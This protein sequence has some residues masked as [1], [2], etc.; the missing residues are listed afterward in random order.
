MNN[1]QKKFYDI[2]LAV[3][4]EIYEKHN[5]KINEI[6]EEIRNKK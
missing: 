1:Y 4:K 5:K 2:K 6:A 3:M